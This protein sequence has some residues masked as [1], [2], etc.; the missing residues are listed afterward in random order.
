MDREAIQKRFGIVGQSRGLMQVIDRIRQVSRTDITVLFTGESGVGKELFATTL[1]GLSERKHKDLVV[2]NCGAIPE[3]LIESELFGSDKGAYTGSVEKRV[4]YFERADKGTIFLDEIGEMPLQAQV[5]LLR[6][7]ENGSFSR[8]G[9]STEQ[10]VD[11]RIIAATNKDLGLEVQEGRF[12]EDLYYRLSTVQIDIPPLRD[13][14]DDILPIFD[15]FL[16]DLS[17]KYN[18]PVKKLEGGATELLQRYRWPGNVREL[19]NVAE[20]ATIL[21]PGQDIREDQIAGFLRG[22]TAGGSP[23]LVLSGG[24]D[25]DRER[26]LLYR[27][28]VDIKLELQELREMIHGGRVDPS[29]S[30]SYVPSRQISNLP[31]RSNLKSDQWAVEDAP[32]A[33]EIKSESQNDAKTGIQNRGK[34]ADAN[35][36]EEGIPTLEAAERKLILATLESFNGNRRKTAK[37]LGIS[38]RT[39]YRKIN[40]Y[41]EDEGNEDAKKVAVKND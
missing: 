8:V 17:S 5:R 22:V 20:Q 14:A 38:E 18:A 23:G 40:E 34:T 37:A 28:L 19:R 35:G 16:H 2:V 36:E 21:V 9:S 15:S 41:E 6:V 32:F 12:R 3:G 33:V 26:E 4:G 29:I 30:T 24:E 11:V 39:L 27:M 10:R 31:V 7:L 13:R 25:Q 1:H